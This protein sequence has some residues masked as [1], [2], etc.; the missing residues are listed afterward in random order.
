MAIEIDHAQVL[1]I[2]LRWIS[3]L[4]FGSTDLSIHDPVQL[5][6]RP[7]FRLRVART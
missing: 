3:S 7:P 5:A 2:G 6:R 4:A 1:I